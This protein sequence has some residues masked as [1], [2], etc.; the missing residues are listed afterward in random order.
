VQTFIYATFVSGQTGNNDRAVARIRC[1]GAHLVIVI[2]GSE[3]SALTNWSA[4]RP[5]WMFSR[6]KFGVLRANTLMQQP[7]AGLVN[8][9]A[10]G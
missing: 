2:R 5:S 10:E 1:L 9:E 4:S 3:P 8:P 7:S 6:I